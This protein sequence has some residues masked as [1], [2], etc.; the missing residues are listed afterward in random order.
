[1]GQPTHAVVEKLVDDDGNAV[2]EGD[3]V[4]EVGVEPEVLVLL[5]I[6]L[7]SAADGDRVSGQEGDEEGDRVDVTEAVLEGETVPLELAVMVPLR[8]SDQLRVPE[9]V[10]VG[11]KVDD[12]AG[13][14]LREAVDVSVTLL[15]RLPERV[16]LPVAVRLDVGVPLLVDEAW[17]VGDGG[18]GT[19]SDRVAVR[20]PETLRDDD[21]E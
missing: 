13:E 6:E 16:A 11:V 12:S 2:R 10:G 5:L 7:D 3:A 4:F 1:M 17:A 21:R 14:S 8:E 19:V 20:D 15:L 9:A 18:S